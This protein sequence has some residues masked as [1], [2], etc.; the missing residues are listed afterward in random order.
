[1]TRKGIILAIII[2]GIISLV[3][4]GG[5]H[6]TNV[7]TNDIAI[8]TVCHELFVPYDAYKGADYNRTNYGVGVGCAE[9]HMYP[10]EEFKKSPHYA[11][12]TGI[13]PSCTACH[14]PHTF[15]QIVRYKF[16]YINKGGYGESPFHA[17]SDSIRDKPEWE[18]LRPR[19]A[20]KVRED[21]LK[22]NSQQCWDCHGVRYD[23]RLKNLKQHKKAVEKKKVERLNCIEC[24]YNLV[25]AEVP[26]PEMEGGGKKQ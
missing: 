3:I 8:C 20:K 2:G 23:A 19:L 17:I 18:E 6:Y 7:R 25:H 15:T 24:H 10:Y 16:L 22:T 14:E 1:M 13:R 12:A 9:C 26:W 4:F 11:N 21:M 5:L